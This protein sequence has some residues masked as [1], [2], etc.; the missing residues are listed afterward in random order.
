MTARL[1]LQTLDRWIVLFWISGLLAIAPSFVLAQVPEGVMPDGA[2]LLPQA[3]TSISDSTIA[4]MISLASE[5]SIYDFLASFTGETPAQLSYGPR[6]IMSRYSPCQGQ[7]WAAQY[8]KEIF[9]GY[10]YTVDLQH[11][12]FETSLQT[13]HVTPDGLGLAAGQDGLI[14][15][16]PDGEAWTLSNIGADTLDVT[17]LSM[18][19][20]TGTRYVVVGKQGTIVASDDGGQTWGVQPSGVTVRL[21]GIDILAGGTG[22]AVG[23]DGTILFTDDS[24]NSWVGQDSQVASAL[25]DVYASDDLTAVVVGDGGVILKTTDGGTNW[26]SIP[27][28]VGTDLNEVEFVGAQGWAVGDGGVILTTID[29]GGTWSSQSSGTSTNLHDVSFADGSHGW[30][31]G[32]S[33]TVLRTSDGGASWNAQV[34]PHSTATLRGVSAPASDVGWAVGLAGHMT[35]T[36]DEGTTWEDRDDTIQAGWVNVEATRTGTTYP[37]EFVLL[38][39]HYDSIPYDCGNAPG[40]DDNGSGIAVIVEAAR[41][42]AEA[43]FERSI[44]FVCFSGEEEGLHGSGAHAARA[45]A[46]GTQIVGVFNLDS[47]GWNDAYFRIFSNDAS[48]WLGDVAYSMATTY[49]PH[50]TVYHWYCPSCDW[51]DHASYWSYGFDAIVGIEPWDPAPPQH[52]TPGDTLGLMDMA[53]VADV[54]KISISTIATVAGVDT[55]FTA[56]GEDPSVS[57]AL[58][59]H[60][61]CAAEPNPFNPS[62]TLRFSIPSEQNVHL[63]V[64]DIRGRLVRTL[65]NERLPAGTHSTVWDGSDALGHECSSGVYFYRMEASAFTDTKKMV[66]LK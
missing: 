10:G 13:I 44:Q 41:I 4:A 51:S 66:M 46:E 61:L 50:L 36:S 60:R 54:T 18:D 63:Q 39:G 34:N 31:V 49:V 40:A 9:E 19:W 58:L 7:S 2:V 42:M 64:F 25:R 27:S 30:A 35:A 43:Q 14:L 53:L 11:F 1:V 15:R 33:G 26:G 37:D 56:A 47:V 8:L 6:W 32:A 52:H 12:R 45:A 5:D 22:W 65:V 3:R 62:T 55:T 16:S 17:F 24:G 38:G 23:G 21:D 57:G 59:T 48:D 29:S 20:V 28:G